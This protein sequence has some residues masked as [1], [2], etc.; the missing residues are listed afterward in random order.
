MAGLFAVMTAMFL[1][2]GIS[3]AYAVVLRELRRINS[4][5]EQFIKLV[6][7]ARGSDPA[8]DDAAQAA[9]QYQPLSSSLGRWS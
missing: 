3:I 2:I 1:T 7:D 5:L 6:V 9:A 8:N 4:N